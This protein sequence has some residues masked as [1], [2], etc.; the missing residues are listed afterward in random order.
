M[1]TKTMRGTCPA[2]FREMDVDNGRMHMHGWRESGGRRAGEYGNAFHTGSC[3]GVG[4]EPFEISPEGTWT[5]LREALFHEALAAANELAHYESRPTLLVE[6][7]FYKLGSAGWGKGRSTESRVVEMKPGDTTEVEYEERGYGTNTRTLDYEKELE[8]RL[9][10]ARQRLDWA[11][12]SG[13]EVYA[14][15]EA[16]KPGKLKT[17]DAKGPTVHRVPKNGKSKRPWCGSNSYYAKTTEVDDEVTCSRCC[18]IMEREKA[19]AAEREAEKADAETLT[20]WLTEHGGAVKSKDIKKALGGWDTK[21]FNKANDW[22]RDVHSDYGRPAKYMAK[23]AYEAWRK[24]EY[25]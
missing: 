20:K 10:K 12:R 7:T 25:A 19:E 5:Y 2:C 17:K 11:K 14:K 15:A 24:K 6:Y 23:D 22:A 1:A 8:N 13:T 18:K 4:F 21:R 9:R 16:W 3:F